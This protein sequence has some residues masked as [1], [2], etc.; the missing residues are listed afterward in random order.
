MLIDYEVLKFIWWILIGALLVGFAIADGMDLGVAILLPFLG[1]TEAER[2]QIVA[3]VTPHWDGN[4]VWLITAGG[5]IFAAWPLVYAAAFSGL[6]MALLLVLFALFFRPLAFD[7]REKLEDAKWRRNWDKALFGG[8]LIPALVFGVAFGNLL[9]GLPFH[10]DNMMR[11]QYEGFLLTALLPLLNPF[12]LLAGIVSVAMLVT[13][14]AMW[15][16]MRTE[17][18]VT[19]RA[20]QAV[21]IF[22]P[23]T[24]ILFA[25]AGL[26][27]ACGID[28]YKIISQPALDAK[29]APL[30][31]E[32]IR[33]AG[34]WLVNYKQYPVT[35]L[36]PIC[37]FGGML[38]AFLLSVINRP[39]KGFI[40][41]ALGITG[42]IGTAGLS[43]FP[44]IMPSRTMPNSSLTMWDAT[45]SHLTLTIMLGAVA[46]F[47]PIVLGY[48]TWCYVRMW[49]KIRAELSS[50][51]SY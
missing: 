4:Q 13:H 24:I 34:A 27:I 40:A 28:G 49:G 21:K 12:A 26:W 20:R 38:L 43:L 6:Y 30:D 48:T 47:L 9:L 51:S 22:A 3:T 35:I 14:G 46:I 29:P 5:A 19:E 31:K 16:Q 44:F 10:L 37:G 45:S 15:L 11:S 23:L 32:V 33:E 25:L 2:A 50:R 17:G 42:I 8:S 1:K 7:Y 18:P 39:G 41:S 36:A